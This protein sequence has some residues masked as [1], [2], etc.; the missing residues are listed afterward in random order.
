MQN[1]KSQVL[2]VG[3]IYE[4]ETFGSSFGKVKLRATIS[5]MPLY[6]NHI[7][8]TPISVEEEKS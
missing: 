2:S 7:K 8:T 1:G 6:H 4:K 5:E 3:L